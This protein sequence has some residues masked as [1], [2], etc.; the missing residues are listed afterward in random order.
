MRK[1]GV[2]NDA[3]GEKQAVLKTRTLASCAL[4]ED[5]LKRDCGIGWL[6]CFEC[7]ALNGVG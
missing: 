2:Y 5:P 6:T 3:N 1:K 7:N 4:G